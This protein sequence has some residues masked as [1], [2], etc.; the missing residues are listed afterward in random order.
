MKNLL[1]ACFLMLFTH[2][3]AQQ[4]PEALDILKA[5]STKVKAYQTLR[6]QFNFETEDIKTKKSNILSGSALIKG[7]KYKLS[8]LG[9]TVFFDGTTV[10]NYLPDA[11]EVNITDPGKQDDLSIMNPL[12]FF[13]IYEKDF[14][15]RYLGEDMLK[16]VTVQII[17]LYPFDLKKPYA[18]I[19]L[20][21]DKSKQQ[22]VQVKTFTKDGN[23]FTLHLVKFEPNVAANDADFTFKKADYP[24]V[25]VIDLRNK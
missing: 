13:N 9:S 3:Q 15:I 22:L 1:I 17:D 14:K 24:G 7:E 6:I 20:T 16:G 11:K 5:I 19:R 23:R 4:D 12:S 25:E 8:M 21:I 18:R 2:V 10:W